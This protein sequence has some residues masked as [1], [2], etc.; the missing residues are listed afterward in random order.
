MCLKINNEVEAAVCRGMIVLPE[1]PKG[2]YNIRG[3]QNGAGA[4]KP[5]GRYNIRGAH[6]GLGTVGRRRQYSTWWWGALQGSKVAGAD[7][8]GESKTIGSDA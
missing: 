3:A 1:D 4:P 7:G 5:K 8:G 6:K 2:R